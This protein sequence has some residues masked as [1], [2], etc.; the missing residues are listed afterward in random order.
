[1]PSLPLLIPPGQ[2]TCPRCGPSIAIPGAQLLTTGSNVNPL[3]GRCNRCEHQYELT[4]GAP[5]TST[6]TTGAANTQGAV[7]LTVAL[8]TSF[9][10]GMWVVVDSAS[11]DGGAEVLK[12]SA[13]GGATSIPIAA[14]PPRLTH[15]GRRDGAGGHAGP[16]RPDDVRGLA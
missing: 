1:M 12:A 8:G 6:T 4:T 7:A 10:L 16:A 11:I 13:A 3:A 2:F 14:T 15:A 5:S 9:T